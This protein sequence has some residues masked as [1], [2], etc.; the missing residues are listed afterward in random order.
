MEIVIKINDVEIYRGLDLAKNI[1]RHLNTSEAMIAAIQKLAIEDPSY[2]EQL[3]EKWYSLLLTVTVALGSAK[4]FYE[5]ERLRGRLEIPLADS[6]HWLTL[7]R[8]GDGSDPTRFGISVI[9]KCSAEELDSLV[10]N[11]AVCWDARVLNDLATNQLK[12]EESAAVSEEALLQCTGELQILRQN[13]KKTVKTIQP[14]TAWDLYCEVVN[15]FDQHVAVELFAQ[16]PFWIPQHSRRLKFEKNGD[17]IVLL[18]KWS[19]RRI[20][21]HAR[22]IKGEV[23]EAAMDSVDYQP[24]APY[25]GTI[26]GF[27][28]RLPSTGF[29]A[30]HEE[31]LAELARPSTLE[32]LKATGE[33]SHHVYDF[34]NFV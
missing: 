15:E 6:A 18:L 24:T 7:E 17:T 21:D 19:A 20:T 30:H 32:L 14:G 29:G 9:A 1:E 4:V 26:A 11:N 12:A 2:R 16:N 31:I 28:D 33:F 22:S 27:I 23:W 10:L 3:L 8:A 13:A 25:C 5:V 34:E